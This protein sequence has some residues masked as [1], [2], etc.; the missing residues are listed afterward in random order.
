MKLPDPKPVTE[1]MKV[2]TQGLLTFILS[3]NNEIYY[4]RGGFNGM[5]KK[6]DY[7]KVRELIRQHAAKTTE[8]DLMFL[9]KSTPEASF[10]NSIDILDEMT[11]NKIPPGHYAEVEITKEEADKITIQKMTKNG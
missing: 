5:I 9:I 11:I 8:E 2:N 3:G 1:E 6:T 4:Y 7:V 10:K